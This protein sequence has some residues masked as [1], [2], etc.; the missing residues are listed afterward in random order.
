MAD[1]GAW[2]AVGSVFLRKRGLTMEAALGILGSFIPLL[3]LGGIIFLVAKLM[4]KRDKT[5]DEGAGVAIRRFFQYSVMLVM[6]VLASFGVSGLINAAVSAGSRITTDT[7]ETALSIAFVFVGLPVFVG[8]AIYTARKLRTDPREQHS[9]GWAVYLT[10]ALFG[11]LVTVMSLAGAFLAE[12]LDDRS[13]DRAIGINA[14]VWAVVWVGHWWVARRKGDPQRLQAQL[15]LGSAAGLIVTFTGITVGATVVLSQIYDWLF[16]VSIINLG[17]EPLVGSLIILVVGV[18]VWW[19]YWFRH[20]RYLNRGPLWLAYVLLLG[21]LGGA[22][23]VIVGTGVMVFGVLAWLI[24]D[25]GTASAVSHFEFIP[26]A[27]G[28]VVAGSVSWLY[29]ATL[30]GERGER[31][32]TEVDR[33][34][35]YLLS[36]AGLIV[37]A[38]GVTTLITVSLKALAGRG[39]TSFQSGNATAVALTLLVVGVPLWWRYWAT[40][41]RYRRTASDAEL[42]SVTRRIYI[43]LL[44]GVAGII[45]VVNLIVIVFIIFDDILVGDF[46]SITLDTASVPIALLLTAGAV[47]GYH[48]VIFREDRAAMHD[49]TQPTL[50]RAVIVGTR[51][52]PIV[53]SIRSDIGASVTVIDVTSDPIIAADIQEALTILQTTDHRSMVVIPH[54]D[55]SYRIQPTND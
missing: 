2:L 6:L 7:A 11:S 50:A 35:D 38:S 16:G 51:T 21:V 28:S 23:A 4:S 54:E 27:I 40:I 55:G 45:A 47:A 25:P 39:L 33:V 10:V 29:H 44:F 53:G 22:I 15:L 31:T 49:V 46:G 8:L 37:A 12:L 19:W 14:T 32:R 43:F 13:V 48:F 5:T 18:P 41:Q 30:L 1:L 36:G 42:R 26:A 9:T 52:D 20:G 3:I 24:G 17:R 34:Y